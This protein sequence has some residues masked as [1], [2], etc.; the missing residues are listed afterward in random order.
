MIKRFGLLLI[1]FMAVGSVCSADVVSWNYNSYGDAYGERATDVAGVVPY[2][3]SYW[4][5]SWLDGTVT[6]LPDSTGTPTTIDISWESFN[7][8]Y[9]QNSH[10]GVDDDG[11][12]SKE[13]LNGYLNSGPAGWGP[14]ITYSAVTL[15]EIEY[16]TYDIVVYFSSDVA[17]REGEVTDGT[18]TYYFNT[19][20]PDSIAQGNA[21]FV[22]TTETGEDYTTAANYAV[23]TGLSGDTQ[24]ITVQMRDDDEWGGIAAIQIGDFE[25]DYVTSFDPANGMTDVSV[26]LSDRTIA[27]NL[28]W[29]MPNDPNIAEVKGYDIYLDPNEAKV[30]ARD[31]GCLVVGSTSSGVTQ[32]DPASDFSY[33]T[34]YYWTVDTRYTS[35]G[36]PELGTANETVFVGSPAKP[37]K[38]TTVS[39]APTIDPYNSVV[40]TESMLPVTVSAVVTDLDGDLAT[41]EFTLLT[42]DD[43]YPNP[44]S[45]SLVPDVSDPYAPGFTFT[46]DTLGY[47]KVM[48][49]VSDGANT[50]EDIAEIA[51]YADD[52]A[53]AAAQFNWQTWEGFNA[54]DFNEDC[55]VNIVDFADVA[56]QWLDDQSLTEPENYSWTIPYTPVVSE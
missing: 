21:L 45:Y 8:W 39:G 37:W 53:C 32:Y 26:D 2:S 17:G 31:A 5:D 23:F 29:V 48:L 35:N 34:E 46:A 33:L 38:F 15:S 19:L 56:I 20:G 14:S 42:D 22:Q 7:T 47:Y 49:T 16:E 10:P 40:A 1:G 24:T 18:T 11:S 9:V 36:D 27:D 3:A 50:I 51:I 52:D 55:H 6:D 12:Y 4:N 30:I 43:N 54:M 44:G 28:S 13:I 41:A 25:V